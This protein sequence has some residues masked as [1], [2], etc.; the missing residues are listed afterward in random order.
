MVTDRGQKYRK[1]ATR[2]KYQRLYTHLCNLPGREW[3]TTFGEIE[4][5][6]GFELPPSARL[7]RPWWSNQGGGNGH[8]QALAWGAA[9]WKTAEVNMDVET[10]LFRKDSRPEGTRKPGLDEIWPVHPTAVWPEGLRLGRED[11]HE[12]M[13]SFQCS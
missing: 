12:D 8:S 9:G 11:R 7:H 10:L 6:I 5:I 4:T 3:R 1:M 13:V 2:G